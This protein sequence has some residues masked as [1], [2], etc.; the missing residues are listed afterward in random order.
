M[1]GALQLTRWFYVDG[2]LTVQKPEYKDLV[3][4][5]G[6]DPSA[7]NGNQIIR[8]PKLFGNIRPTV[9][10][11]TGGNHVEMYGRYEYTSKRYVDFFNSTALP[12]Y[13]EFGAGVTITRG[14]WQFQVVGDNLTDAHG[15]TEGNTRT[16]TLAGQGTKDAVYARPIFGRSA[17]FVLS[18]SW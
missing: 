8:E 5:A 15:L 18:K 6:A 13:G 1:D 10:F 16:D 7:V 11:D 12:A 4:G 2:S 3:N 9:S 14:S 17:R